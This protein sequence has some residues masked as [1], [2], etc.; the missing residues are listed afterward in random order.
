MTPYENE[1]GFFLRLP[2]VYHNDTLAHRLDPFMNSVFPFHVLFFD[3]LQAWSAS[4]EAVSGA[5]FSDHESAL[6][7]ARTVD[8]DRYRVA[9]L[10]SEDVVIQF[11]IRPP[12]D[13]TLMRQERVEIP[14]PQRPDPVR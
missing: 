9:V 11:L 1:I 7:F 3:S 5:G 6:L 4:T 8:L 14:L 12:H 13:A 10:V 2:E